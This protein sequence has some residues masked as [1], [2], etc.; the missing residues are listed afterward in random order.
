M[1]ALFKRRRWFV[2]VALG[3]FALAL[4][5]IIWFAAVYHSFMVTSSKQPLE[6]GVS[7]SSDYARELGLDPHQTFL[8]LLDQL[9][10]KRFRLMSYWD[11]EEPKP[12]VYDFSD[13]DFQMNHAAAAGAKVSLAIGLRQPRWPECHEPAWASKLSTQQQTAQLEGFMTVVVKRYRGN[14]A[15]ESYQLENEALNTAFG[16]CKNFQ[17]SR[18][19]A[20]FNLVKGLDPNHPIIVSVSNEYGLP[21]GQPKGDE[22]GFSVY[23]HIYDATITKRYITYPFP[24]WYFGLKAALIEKLLHRPVMIHELQTE[25]WGP[26][27]TEDLTI[28]QQNQSMTAARVLESVQY[29]QATG[30]RQYYLWG[31]E[32]WYWRLTKFHDPSLWNAAKQ[33]YAQGN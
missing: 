25:P 33:I 6:P 17:R 26:K 12:G 11:S 14:S 1:K 21:L 32:W 23:R 3:A 15:L 29:A 10:V 22:V 7:F 27:P 9:H 13:L 19:V 2:W 31:G 28:A 18:L 8:A 20:E 24:A 4:G 16:T 30:I 5:I